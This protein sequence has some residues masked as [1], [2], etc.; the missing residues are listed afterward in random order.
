MEIGW[1]D[2]SAA[3][4][5]LAFS[6]LEVHPT[7][8]A[9]YRMAHESAITRRACDRAGTRKSI[10]GAQRRR[11]S[12]DTLWR[13]EVRALQEATALFVRLMDRAALLRPQ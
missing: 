2:V 10:S 12:P 5:V 9:A 1:S 4:S 13:P 7:L 3:S 8:L 11:L 6:L